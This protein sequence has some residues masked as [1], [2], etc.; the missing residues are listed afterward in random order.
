[1]N[2]Q[3][4]RGAVISVLNQTGQEVARGLV[5][6]SSEEIEKILRLPSHQIEAK[7][8]YVAEEEVLHRDNLVIRSAFRTPV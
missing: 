4:H 6:Y 7:L 5:N 3:F 8:G 2:G 1:M